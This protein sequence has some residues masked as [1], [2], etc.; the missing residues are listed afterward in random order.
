MRIIPLTAIVGIVMYHSLTFVAVQAC[1]RRGPE[2]DD[3][4][5]SLPQVPRELS[6]PQ[7]GDGTVGARGGAP[8]KG[9]RDLVS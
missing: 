5:A 3:D 8:H 9:R 2:D 7:H 1:R 6:R 4:E